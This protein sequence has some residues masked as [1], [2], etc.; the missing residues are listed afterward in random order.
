[1]IFF[2]Y[3]MCHIIY[4]VRGYTFYTITCEDTNSFQFP[5]TINF[6]KMSLKLRVIHF[7]IY[8]PRHRP[9]SIDIYCKLMDTN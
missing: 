4:T 6:V 2:L 3:C 9:K 5:F 1:M 8:T 7:L